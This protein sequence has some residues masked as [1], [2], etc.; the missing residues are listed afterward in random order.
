VRQLDGFDVDGG[1]HMLEHGRHQLLLLLCRTVT[2]MVL[3]SSGY[4]VTMFKRV[5]VKVSQ[6]C[7]RGTVICWNMAIINC[8]SSLVIVMV[9]ESKS[10]GVRE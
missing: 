5:T 8:F 1:E 4:G 10:N 2:V 7:M 3:E 9:L 6:V